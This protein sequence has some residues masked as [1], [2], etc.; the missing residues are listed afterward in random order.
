MD[1]NRHSLEETIAI[2]AADHHGKFPKHLSLSSLGR[3]YLIEIPKINL[4]H[5]GHQESAVVEEYPFLDSSGH[6]DPTKLKDTCH[7]LY[8]PKT[9]IVIVDCTHPRFFRPATRVYEDLNLP[10]TRHGEARTHK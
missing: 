6:V 8:D 10:G 4:S 1:G 7:W 5:L 3:E 2:Y 9:G